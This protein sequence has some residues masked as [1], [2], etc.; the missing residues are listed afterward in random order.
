M[1]AFEKHPV[2][3][4]SC[5]EITTRAEHTLVGRTDETSLLQH[6]ERRVHG[7]ISSLCLYRQ[8]NRVE[9]TGPLV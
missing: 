5:D 9:L 1:G 8:S 7:D 2:Y 4:V 6:T 3:S